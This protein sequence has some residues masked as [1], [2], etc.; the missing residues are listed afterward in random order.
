LNG[1]KT[2]SENNG[3]K[4]YRQIIIKKDDGI[5]VLNKGM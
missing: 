5:Y 3:S 2:S 4:N 1:N